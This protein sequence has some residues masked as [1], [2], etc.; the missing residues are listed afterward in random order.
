MNTPIDVGVEAAKA[1][2]ETA[3]LGQQVVGLLEGS[4]SWFS[5]RLTEPLDAAIGWAFTDNLQH[6]RAA[7]RIRKMERLTVLAHRS[8]A[9]LDSLG[10]TTIQ[11]PSDRL[12]T[13]LVEAAALEDDPN[14]QEMWAELMTQALTEEES[15]TLQWVAI[16]RDLRSVDA[17]ALQSYYSRAPAV[18][19]K[20]Q[21][22]GQLV[23][24]LSG[25]EFGLQVAR[26]LQRLGLIEPI[27]ITYSVITDI[28]VRDRRVGV[29]PRTA[30]AEY[31]G[32]L[33]MVQLTETGVGFCKAVGML[34]PAQ[35]SAT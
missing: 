11:S 1:T 9:R 15:D 3:K 27:T 2:Q 28:D 33:Y 17:V 4:L 23:E 22:F 18:V 8:Q 6:G 13:N 10:I 19:R 26:N 20:D 12:L 34:A 25:E 24:S 5:G 35:T 32:G 14:L 31:S 30:E 7:S 29:E 16:L 21:L